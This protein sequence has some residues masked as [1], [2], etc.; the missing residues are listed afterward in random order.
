MN[1]HIKQGKF[2]LPHHKQAALEVFG[3]Q[4]FVEQRARQLGAVVFVAAHAGQHIVF[5]HKVFHKLAGQFHCIPFH[6]VDA[7]H[8]QFVYLGEQVVQAVSHFVKQG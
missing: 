3:R 5:P 7:G 1:Q 2:H 6:A 8:A 4:H